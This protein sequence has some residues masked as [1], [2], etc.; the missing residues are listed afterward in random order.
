[1]NRITVDVPVEYVYQLARIAVARGEDIDEVVELAIGYSL[2][3]SKFL[4]GVEPPVEG[5]AS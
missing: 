4:F 1:M 5:G 3:Q 2:S